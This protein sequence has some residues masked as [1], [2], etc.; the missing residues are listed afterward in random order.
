V[1]LLEDADYVLLVELTNAFPFAVAPPD[2]VRIIDDVVDAKAPP[3][4]AED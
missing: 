3:P 2:L 1:L 4:V